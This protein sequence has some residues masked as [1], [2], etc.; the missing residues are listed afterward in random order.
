MT[1]PFEATGDNLH[2][3]VEIAFEGV[4]WVPFD[5]T[6]DED[7]VPNDQTTTPQA[8]PRPQVLQPPPPAQSR[9]TCLP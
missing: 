6:P 3:W 1:E 7:N 4:G 9:P 5:P 2:V 8:N